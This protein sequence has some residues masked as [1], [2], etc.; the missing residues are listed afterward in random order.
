MSTSQAFSPATPYVALAVAFIL[1]CT[2][3]GCA[4]EITGTSFNDQTAV[5]EKGEPSF[6][7]QPVSESSDAVGN[8]V[9][10]DEQGWWAKDGF[11]H[12]G[13]VITNPNDDLIARNTVITITTYDKH[14]TKLTGETATVSFIG[15]GESIGYAG[16]AGEGLVPDRV[17][18]TVDGATTVWQD[19]DGYT[20]I[21][22]V[23]SYEEQDK[24]YF[25]YEI[26]GKVGNHTG[27][28]VS[29]VPLC[30]LLR[31]DEGN[32]VAGYTGAAYRI[33]DGRSKDF[34]VTMHSAPS[35]A[36]VDIYPQWDLEQ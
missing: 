3:A 34:T 10:I 17:D 33:K 13:I 5:F 36:S 1:A 22:T 18:I 12:Y 24:L 15:P 11:V 27:G 29:N 6:M 8:D 20:P 30:V 14:G 2:L 25:R 26:T 21:F 32:I 16:I 28:Y 23:D 19:A 4:T 35:H 31:D 7:P 9:T